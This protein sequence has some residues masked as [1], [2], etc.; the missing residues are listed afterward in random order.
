M[1][2]VFLLKYKLHPEP[3]SFNFFFSYGMAVY[4]FNV[5]YILTAP[6]GHLVEQIS[7]SIANKITLHTCFFLENSAVL[8][9]FTL[10]IIS[11]SY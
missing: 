4:N 9:Y 6:A 1:L 8:W 5:F 11:K 3:S 7:K 2:L 10:K